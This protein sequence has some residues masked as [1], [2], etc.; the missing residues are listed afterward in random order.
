MTHTRSIP[1]EEVFL[2]SIVAVVNLLNQSTARPPTP[3]AT[4]QSIVINANYCTFANDFNSLCEEQR[5]ASERTNEGVA[6]E[7]ETGSFMKLGAG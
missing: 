6:P 4:L 2:A 5:K 3:T 1:N 7:I